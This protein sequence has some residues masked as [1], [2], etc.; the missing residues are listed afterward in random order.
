MEPALV[1][2]NS[3]RSPWRT[4]TIGPGMSPSNVQ[5]ATTVSSRT[6]SAVSRAVKWSLTTSCVDTGGSAG[7]NRLSRGPRLLTRCRRSAGGAVRLA[8]WPAGGQG[9]CHRREL[10]DEAPARR[11]LGQALFG[12][13]GCGILHRWAPPE[14]HA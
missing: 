9:R 7:S 6:R 10:E 11:E 14:V 13:V 5:A 4:W 3:T 8:V 12:V 2:V 1:N